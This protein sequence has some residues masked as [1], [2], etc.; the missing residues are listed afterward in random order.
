MGLVNEL[1]ESAERDD[2][3]TV[4]RK[5]KRVSSK[6]G[7]RDICDWLEHEQNGYPDGAAVPEYR[8]VPPTFC[9]DTNGY[10]P[11]GY[12]QLMKGIVPLPPGIVDG[13]TMPLP[14]REAVSVVL[15]LIES[16]KSGKGVFYP[17]PSG[18]AEILRSVFTSSQPEFLRRVTFLA[19]LDGARTRAIPEHIK[20]RVLDWACELEAAG[21]TGDDQSFSPT[22]KQAAQTVIFNI[23]H[24]N[25]DQL[26]NSGD[27]VKRE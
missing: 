26:N 15:D 19:Q 20:N 25:I 24:S 22:E 14:M 9:Y 13:N 21:V 2:V 27:N 6:L 16:M 12:G 1:Q 7:R 5:A 10:V 3:L 4:L 23:N 8:M 17:L 11:A 18:A